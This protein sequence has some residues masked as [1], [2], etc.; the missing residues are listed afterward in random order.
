MRYVIRSL[1]CSTLLL[2]AMSA[3]AVADDQDGGTNIFCTVSM[4]KPHTH[5]L[6]VEMRITEHGAT[7]FDE[8]V[9]VMPVWTPGSYL[10]REY[11]RHVQNLSAVDESGRAL[12]WEKI[13]KNSWRIKTNN[14]RDIRV[15]YLVYANEFTVRT[16]ELNSDHAFWNNTA[17]LM[18]L[19][20]SLTHPV[21]IH[22]NPA[23]GWKVATGL[24]AVPGEKNTFEAENFDVLYDS[25]F[26]V[27]DFKQIDFTVRGVPHRIVIDGEG[28]YDPALMKAE[29]QKIVEAEVALFGDVPYHDYTFILHLRPTGGGGLEHL[30]STALGFRRFGFA[31]DNGYRGFAGLVAHEFFHVWNVKR[32]RPDALGPF[33]YT[34]ENYTRLLWVAEG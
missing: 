11:E 8:D 14:A 33:D 24:P 15:K 29:V 20:R 18:Y 32:I 6:E 27:S 26:E 21:K 30:N 31:N 10:I 13:N 22:V 25:P 16:N 23:P 2:L 4:S 17:L 1:F 28:N 5:L 12:P 7:Y 9:L 19:E 34:K 3:V